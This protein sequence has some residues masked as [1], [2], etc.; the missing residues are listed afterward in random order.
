MENLRKILGILLGLLAIFLLGFEII[1][2][3]ITDLQWSWFDYINI[4]V[5]AFAGA[6]LIG[7]P[8]QNF[9]GRFMG[10]L[11]WVIVTF[12]VLYHI[13]NFKLSD[14]DW[15]WINYVNIVVSVFAGYLLF[16]RA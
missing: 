7:S 10:A 11:L 13:E 1:K 8:A 9:L 3:E 16:R 6:V 4:V 12:L 5:G 15:D 14:I 2:F